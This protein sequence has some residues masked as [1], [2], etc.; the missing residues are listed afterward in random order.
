MPVPEPITV[1]KDDITLG[2]I[3]PTPGAGWGGGSIPGAHGLHGRNSLR[4][5]IGFVW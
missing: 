2:T 4:N 1:K 5:K 3:R